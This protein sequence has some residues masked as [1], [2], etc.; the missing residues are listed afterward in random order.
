MAVAILILHLS[1]VDNDILGDVGSNTLLT[2]SQAIT[3]VWFFF[4]FLAINQRTTIHL[5]CLTHIVDITLLYT[6]TWHNLDCGAASALY[7]LLSKW[8]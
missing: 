4:F 3:I 6:Y 8:S 1:V 7:F 2:G 5:K